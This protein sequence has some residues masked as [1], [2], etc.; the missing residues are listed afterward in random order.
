MVKLAYNLD[1]TVVA[2]GIETEYQHQVLNQ[3]GCDFCQGNYFS[4]PLIGNKYNE[5]SWILI[6]KIGNIFVL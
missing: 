6:S 3:Y 4:K 1:L 5:L 2:E